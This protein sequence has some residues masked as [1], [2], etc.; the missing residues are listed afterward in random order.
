MKAMQL[1]NKGQPLQMVDLPIPEPGISEVLI[2][3]NACGVCRTDVHIVDEELADI[4]YPIVPGHQIVGKVEKLGKSVTR[5][6]LGERV[7]V[8]WLSWTCGRCRFCQKGKENLCK[9]AKFT[10][11]DVNGGF[12]QYCVANENYC[13]KI[14]ERYDDME[15]APLLCAGLV[16]FRAYRMVEN[17]E[18]IGFYGFGSSAHILIQIAKAQ[19]KK[20]YVFTRPGDDEGQE[21]ARKLGAVWVGSSGEM[22]PH[23]LEGVIIFAPV[24]A[25]IPQA[26]KVL[27]PGG[28]V[29]CAGIHMSDIPTFHYKLLWSE[30]T[31]TTIANL[32]RKD[33]E[34]FL[35]LAQ[36]IPLKLNINLYKFSEI[37]QALSDVRIGNINGSAVMVM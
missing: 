37:N 11:K 6:S 1:F 36:K 8:G 17:F 20:V 23:P 5:F 3:I 19:G 22:P 12:S 2:K 18:R 31:L 14:P 24:G 33:G 13:F 16:G 27:E 28:V 15:A 4:S 9:R 7:G 30:K 32:T 29:V 21:L 26:L 25:L 34:E 10:G 35:K